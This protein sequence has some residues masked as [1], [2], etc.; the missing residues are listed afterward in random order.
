M[1]KRTRSPAAEAKREA[2]KTAAKRL[3]GTKGYVATSMRQI[4]SAVSMEGGSLYYHFAS[5]EELLS[6]LLSEGNESLIRA[7]KDCVAREQDDSI[8][9]LRN[10]MIAHMRIL[11]EDRTRFMIA[12]TDLNRLKS[13]RR[14]KIVAQRSEYERIIQNTIERGIKAGVFRRCNVKI[15]SYAI[16]A[17]MNSVAFWFNPRGVLSLEDI[18]HEQAALLLEGL[19]K[20]EAYSLAQ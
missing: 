14:K 15:A 9:V 7:A 12:T 19:V 20:A 11:V 17:V 18:A 3:F 10:I 16:I 8:T 6:V 5:K 4:A 13:D 1:T 2:I